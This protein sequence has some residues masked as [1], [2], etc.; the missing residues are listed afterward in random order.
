MS[1]LMVISLL[2]PADCEAKLDVQITSALAYSVYFLIL[3]DY[4]PSYLRSEQPA[5]GRLVKNGVFH[6][7][8]YDLNLLR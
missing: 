8:Q 5:I 7:N 6:L 1:S 2:L 3:S 4:I